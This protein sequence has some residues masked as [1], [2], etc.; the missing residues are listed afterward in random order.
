MNGDGATILVVDD[1]PENVRLLEAVLAPP[2]ARPGVTAV[3]RA[4]TRAHA[5]PACA[6]RED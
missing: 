4:R 2:T 6:S 5:R 1:L 3:P